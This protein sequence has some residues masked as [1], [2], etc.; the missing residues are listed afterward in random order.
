MSFTPRRRLRCFLMDLTSDRD[1][2]GWNVAN[3]CPR[4]RILKAILQTPLACFPD[5]LTQ[6]RSASEM[7]GFDYALAHYGLSSRIM[8]MG[9]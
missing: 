7:V 4:L 8:P 2:M 3:R 6:L 5:L 1:C 9:Q